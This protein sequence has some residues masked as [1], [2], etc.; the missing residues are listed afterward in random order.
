MKL[1]DTVSSI[2]RDK[3]QIFSIAPHKSVYEAV[4]LMAEKQIGS[5][6]VMTGDK[7]HGIVSERDYA[8]KVILQGK[9]SKHTAV[10]E[11]MSTSLHTVTRQHTLE[12]CMEIIT[13]QRIRHLP[14]VED[15]QVLGMVSIGDLVRAIISAQHAHIEQ[16]HS[17][18]A[19]NYPR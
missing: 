11:I 4:E 17:Y 18:I 16:L 3:P 5:L 15:G 12:E 1:T 10:S 2:L 14:V 13:E 19:G 9:S 8:R 6:L 7:L